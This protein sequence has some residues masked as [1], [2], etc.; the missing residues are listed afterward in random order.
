[1]DARRSTL[2]EA[3]LYTVVTGEQFLLG[4]AVSADIKA[5]ELVDTLLVRFKVGAPEN[6]EDILR[7]ALSGMNLV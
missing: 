3:M 7:L 2:Y 5:L 6:I 1:M 4:L